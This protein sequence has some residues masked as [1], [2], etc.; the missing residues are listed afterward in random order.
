MRA[1][2]TF[3]NFIEEKPEIKV[4]HEEIVE[5][6]E[7]IERKVKPL[8][9]DYK[10]IPVGT[11]R[12]EHIGSPLK[13]PKKK[14]YDIY[15]E[16]SGGTSKLPPNYSGSSNVAI[17]HECLTSNIENVAIRNE[18]KTYSDYSDYID[19]NKSLSYGEYIAEQI[20]S[21]LCYTEYVAEQLSKI[22]SIPRYPREQSFTDKPNISMLYE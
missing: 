10:E 20:D 7:I 1:I 18:G 21:T 19:Y 22:Q 3:N 4:I 5:R 13:N 16:T 17:G 14:G 2:K 9:E 6:E 11:P 15:K 12:M 8:I